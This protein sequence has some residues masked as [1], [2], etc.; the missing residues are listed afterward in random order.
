MRC[1]LLRALVIFILPQF[2]TVELLL[3]AIRVMSQVNSYVLMSVQ[4]I[5]L[6]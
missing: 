5:V 6:E 1:S 3:L 2:N 4:D